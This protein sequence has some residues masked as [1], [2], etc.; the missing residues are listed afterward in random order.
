MAAE[1]VPMFAKAVR[2][3]YQGLRQKSGESAMLG[4]LFNHY[5]IRRP[6]SRKIR[7]KTA[8]VLVERDR[9]PL[10]QALD[11]ADA[12]WP[13][14]TAL[15]YLALVFAGH[16]RKCDALLREIVASGNPAS[17]A[18][19]M[20]ESDLRK[21]LLACFRDHLTLHGELPHGAAIRLLK[22]CY[23]LDPAAAAIY[24]NGVGNAVRSPL[25]FAYAASASS[26]LKVRILFRKYYFGRVSR[27]HDLGTRFK[28][29]FD[30]AGM[31]CRMWDPNVEDHEMDRADLTLIDDAAMF[32]KDPKRKRVLL[33]DVRRKSRRVCLVEPDPWVP[34][35]PAR[36]AAGCDIYDFV[37]AMA[38][39]TLTNGT[40][41]GMPACV[42]PFP[43]GFGKIF[44]EFGARAAPS[45]RRPLFCGAVENYNFH[46]LY[47]VLAGYSFRRP[48]KADVTSHQADD[49]SIEASIR[50][51]LSRLLASRTCLN[52]T[53]RADGRR[54]VVGRTSDALRA[55]QLLVQEF[56]EE[57][58][59]YFAPGA[60]YV[61]FRTVDELEDI[62]FRLADSRAYESVRAE[63]ARF[64]AERYSD[65]AV[66]RH[67]ATYL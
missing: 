9:A 52:F 4:L 21:F 32:P 42:I 28:T 13:L 16:Y 23:F 14:E 26:A 30:D 5:R 35:F 37:W 43:V 36:I 20:Q 2:I 54:S 17:Y 56:A 11:G 33:E 25:P 47:W 57:M 53:M 50:G 31:D 46:R 60:H 49:L 15:R 6:L 10:L 44:D 7:V 34:E 61:E 58:N 66:V 62:C 38:P 39:T 12:R 65:D 8:Q 51:Y 40:I 64:F 55:G 41:F 67:I 45:S 18:R 59:F 29:P 24:G 48:F 22:F 3:L 63:G 27:L 19:L 1:A